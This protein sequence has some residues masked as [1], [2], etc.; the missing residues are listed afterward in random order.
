MIRATLS[1]LV[2]TVTLG[3]VARAQTRVA[4]RTAVHVESYSFGS[5]SSTYPRASQLSI[6]LGV[7]IDLGRFGNV[8]LS[9]GYA[10]TLLSS[11]VDSVPDQRV[12][13]ATDTQLRLSINLVP[14]R[15]VALVEGA[16]PTGVSEIASTELDAA[17]VISRDLI[18][19]TTNSF[20]TGG[21]LGGGLVGAVPA[22]KMALGFGATYTQP[23]T[24]EPIQPQT[25][26]F[27]LRVGGELRMRAG[28]EGPLGRRSYLRAAGV[29]AVRQNDQVNDS[30]V[31]GVGNRVTGYLTFNQGIG[32]STSLTLYGFDVYRGTPSIEGSALGLSA[33]PKGNLFSLGGRLAVGAGRAAM[34]TPSVEYRLSHAAPP[35]PA[36]PNDPATA[37]S[38]SLQKLGSSVRA[39]VSLAYEIS[40][41][42]ALVLNGSGL[43]GSTVVQNGDFSGF[44]VSLNFSLTP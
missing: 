37:G 33:L 18:G 32:Q 6:P 44:R 8:A 40:N 38:G 42:A 17:G 5:G 36:D 15:L 31:N 3:T 30:T 35:D 2:A 24:Y 29:F 28:L 25:G 26:T 1:L 4:V 21:G 16:L 10:N 27:R 12:A 20:G 22:G 34:V 23:F 14:D 13:G 19:F 7:T 11:D 43:F 39:G 9:G 41:S